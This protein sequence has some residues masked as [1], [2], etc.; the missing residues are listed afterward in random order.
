MTEALPANA[1]IRVSRGNFDPGRL[2]E[3][4]AV[5]TRTS[6]YL[7]PAIRQLPGLIHC[8]AGVSPEG[9]IVQ[10]SVWDT[11][12]HAAQLGRLKEMIVDARGEMEAADVTFTPIVNYPV[13]WTT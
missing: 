6:E 1:V 10:V 4:G 9:S 7:I 13:N 3:V 11:D 5:N 8:Y 12:E 2:A